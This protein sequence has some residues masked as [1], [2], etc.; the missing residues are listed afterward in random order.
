MASI[1]TLAGRSGTPAWILI[2]GHLQRLLL[3]YPALCCRHCRASLAVFTRVVQQ[4]GTCPD[5][6]RR[7]L[8]DAKQQ[9][10]T[11][12]VATGSYDIPEFNAAYR[13]LQ[14][15]SRIRAAGSMLLFF[16]TG[17]GALIM[18]SPVVPVFWEPARP[19]L[20]LMAAAFAACCIVALMRRETIDQRTSLPCQ[21][22]K[23]TLFP[24]RALAIATGN[25]PHC[26]R[27]VI[28]DQ[29]HGR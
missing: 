24:D 13:D 18:L 16:F 2:R 12:D 6:G 27:R 10:P 1:Y 4:T 28:K 7:V 14:F 17:I 5:C 22:C 8:V 3:R 26:D 29:W 9:N 19:W 11:G 15:R 21:H 23:K 25:C 20:A